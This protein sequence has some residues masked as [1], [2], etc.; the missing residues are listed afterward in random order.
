MRQGGREGTVSCG[1]LSK[2]AG[3][4]Q[5]GVGVSRDA[6]GRCGIA[7]SQTARRVED[8]GS[9]RQKS[10]KVGITLT[11]AASAFGGTGDESIALVHDKKGPRACGWK[12]PLATEK[13]ALAR[14]SV[15]VDPARERNGRDDDPTTDWQY[16]PQR[17]RS[18]ADQIARLAKVADEG[19]RG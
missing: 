14:R 10:R 5:D 11:A 1:G 7:V 9:R 17:E 4:T 3:A 8:R 19:Q 2:I 6:S 15:E 18:A 12:S 16:S 13:G